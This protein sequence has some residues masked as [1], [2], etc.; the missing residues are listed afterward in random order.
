MRSSLTKK[1]ASSLPQH[2]TAAQEDPP[3]SNLSDFPA[4]VY[5][6]FKRITLITGQRLK[7]Y[8]GS[9]ATLNRFSTH[10]MVII[11]V[12]TAIS[13]RNVSWL[14]NRANNWLR[15]LKLAPA[16]PATPIIVEAGAPPA[17][18]DQLDDLQ[19]DVLVREAVPR[20]TIPDRTVQAGADHNRTEILTYRVETGDTVYGIAAKFGLAPETIT[21]ANHELED[22]PDV[23]RVGQTLIILPVDGVYHQVG[24]ADTIEGIA[25]TYQADPAAIINFPLNDLNPDNPLIQPGQW[26]VVPGG[27]KPY[28][29]RTVTA[30]SGPVPED[31][32]IGTG[33]FVWPAS[34]RITQGYW[35][36]HPALDIAAYPGAPI[37]AADSGHVVFASWDDTGYGYTVVIDH[38]NGFQTLYAHL[39]EYYVAAGEDVAKGEE[40][41]AMGST[42]NSTG[43]HVNF[44][45]R[46]GTVQRNPL[47]FLP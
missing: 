11:L 9:G 37:L 28:V 23:L 41:A 4:W 24:S 46:Q 33:L 12:I 3:A 21:W 34:G 42:G 32:A 18:P 44:E 26:L 17:L 13:L 27:S 31:A 22:N 7:T 47:G 5:P 2:P 25:A 39:Q 40:I 14:Q 29:P 15:P 36:G 43:P 35:T 6:Q 30:Y 38:G 16:Q 1:P 20:T 8:L 10:L 45:I 19:D